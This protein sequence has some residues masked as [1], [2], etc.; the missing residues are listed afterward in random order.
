V[1]SYPANEQRISDVERGRSCDAILPMP[2][3]K[4]LSAGDHV[5][6][7]LAYSQAGR[8]A[9]YVKGGDAVCV[10]LTDVTDLR[11]TDPATG[12]SLFRLSWEP[13]GPSGSSD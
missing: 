1:N 6:F 5:L 11:A 8:E 2:P 3:G 12:Q 9:C 7:A 13:P 4:T 10:L